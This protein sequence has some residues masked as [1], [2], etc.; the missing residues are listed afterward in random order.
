[1][2]KV[3]AKHFANLIAWCF[4]CAVKCVKNVPAYLAERLFQSMKVS[5]AKCPPKCPR[6]VRLLCV[7]CAEQTVTLIS[8]GV[9]E[10]VKSV[11][12]F[13]C[14]CWIKLSICIP[15]IFSVTFCCLPK[16]GVLLCPG[17]WDHRVCSD[18]D[19][20]QSLGGRSV[21]HQSWVQ[22]AVWLHPVF[23]ARSQ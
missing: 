16:R 22:E 17:R 9:E 12:V 7:C 23:T 18:Q 1:M 3:P 14:C 19:Y 5:W 13:V 10:N 11:F 4:F 8:A 6:T 21:G 15:V 20:R 2:L